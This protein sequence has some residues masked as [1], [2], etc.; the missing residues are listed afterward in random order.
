MR[1]PG[2]DVS[3]G[4][5]PSSAKLWLAPVLIAGCLALV[6]T[7]ADAAPGESAADAVERRASEL[8]GV[9]ES[10]DSPVV[11]VSHLQAFTRIGGFL[12]HTRRMQLLRR[13]ADRT[14]SPLVQFR[15][16]RALTRAKL[17]GR[18][19]A[20]G[21][22]GMEGPLGEQ[23]CLRHW[24]VVGPFDNDSMQAFDR[25]LA[26]EK[27]ASGP[28][29]GKRIEV[30]WRDLP[31]S[32]GDLCTFRLGRVLEPTGSAVAYLSTTIEADRARRARLLVGADGAYKVWVNGRPVGRQ[33]TDLGL[34]VD[35]QAW[36]ISLERGEN[37]MLVK[38]ASKTGADLGFAARVVGPDLAPLDV[39]ATPASN[40][41]TV[42]AF[43]GD[44]SVETTKQGLLARA[45]ACAKGNGERA[46]HCA[47][48]WSALESE[49]AA[50]PW[51]SAAQRLAEPVIGSGAD[52]AEKVGLSGR[53]LA[54]LSSLLDE[55]S[56]RVD[57]LEAA[58]GL[59][60]DDPWVHLRL[61]RALGSSAQQLTRRRQREVLVDLRERWPAFWPAAVQ[62]SSWYVGRGYHGRALRILDEQAPERALER[63]AYLR[64]LANLADSA[65]ERKRA[66]ELHRK[67]DQ[68]A[69]LDSSW[70]WRRVDELLAAERPKR[71][72][73]L[74]RA[75]RR[76]QPGSTRWA[77]KEIDI[78][79]SLDRTQEALG[80]LDALIDDKPG[81]ARLRRKKAELL[82][83]LDRRD[84]AVESMKVATQLEPQ[85]RGMREYL[86]HLKPGGKGYH[87]PWMIEDVRKLAEKTEKSPYARETLVDQTIV[88][89]EPN[90]LY[91][92]VVQ[93]VVRVNRSEGVDGASTHSV[94]YQD[95]D[96]QVDVL[97]VKVHKP[98]GT[99]LED[100][101]SWK[102]KSSGGGKYY[103][104][105][106]YRHMRANNVEAGD[107][108]EFRYRIRQIAN[109]NF[110]G[111]YF[112]D[113]SYLQ[114]DKPIALERYVVRHPATMDL[115]LR[116]P[117][118]EHS[119]VD[120]RLPD[121]SQPEKGFRVRGVELKDVPAVQTDPRQP[122]YTDVYDY[123]MVSNKKTW[124]AVGEWWW[125]LVE[126]QLILDDQIRSKTDELIKGLESD[127]AKMEAIHNW[128]VKNTRYLH[129]GLGIHGWKPYQTTQ[130]FQ[131]K[132]GDCKD[133]ASLLKVMLEHAGIDTNLVLV[134]TRDRGSIAKSPASMH[135]FNHAIDY[136]PKFDLF[137]DPTAEFNG[138][139]EL[140]AMDQ[141]AQ[142]LIVKDGGETRF[143]RMPVDDASENRIEQTLTVDLGA[144]PTVTKGRLVARGLKAVHYRE[145][146]DDPERRDEKFEKQLASVYPGATLVSAT[147][148]HLDDL[149]KPVEIE[150]TFEGGRILRGGEGQ[151]YVFPYGAPKD[152]QSRF[153]GQTS[154]NQD[155]VLQVPFQNHTEVTFELPKGRTFTHVPESTDIDSEFGRARVD[156][157]R[158]GRSLTADVRYQF[159][160]H[161]IPVEQY[162]AFRTFVSRATDALTET[163]GIGGQ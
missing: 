150:F 135:V 143:T 48:L 44:T 37:R 93:R 8:I 90:G 72:L 88:N 152:L 110:R 74:V 89:V 76:L 64:R 145:A 68:M 107:L 129:V 19:F 94:S 47:V 61:A 161:R 9:V 15:A 122:G 91:R 29:E 22:D 125:N 119:R 104:D 163:V 4:P 112:G 50:E 97:D 111:D 156:Y 30:R 3:D 66:R 87:E 71:A 116:E 11:A 25:R 80:K 26:P 82:V 138:T 121:G 20:V 43:D 101:D 81:I 159:D 65:G 100:Y 62:L 137:L 146:L 118:L 12:P 6:S 102:N 120:G 83:A 63:P 113:I 33:Q 133:K 85:N 95:G 24:R 58:T 67:L 10:S 148:H 128:V 40:T 70:R 56:R 18:D 35:N 144:D 46:V 31:P 1:Q 39:R 21:H 49:P 75:R 17:N 132:Y 60:P 45:R 51:R 114:G 109:E 162:S 151:R 131:N 147:Y 155:L 154:R 157:R 117:A 7:R 141:N 139:T 38:L 86:D 36:P 34:A 124:D 55:H 52:H 28:Y 92:K 14:E 106:A 2:D 105:Q 130:C 149:E 127:R 23:G 16:L 158:E 69:T 5:V 79:R 41:S 123:V 78:L 27:G 98:D 153:A 99:V 54:R 108:V 13:A 126:E 103:T 134:R 42:E 73:E 57:V 115:Y 84:E 140:P 59:A 136:V 53:V 96:E 160:H 142:A 77:L 32:Y